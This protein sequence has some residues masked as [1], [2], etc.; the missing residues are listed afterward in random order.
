M[1]VDTPAG[2]RTCSVRVVRTRPSPE[3]SP[4]GRGM[5]V[6]YPRQVGQ[7]WAVRMSPRKLRWIW[8]TSPAP[9][10]VVQVTGSEPGSPP[11]PLHLGHTTAVSTLSGFVTPKTASCSWSET[12]T[13]ASWPWRTRD[14]GPRPPAAPNIASTRLEKSNPPAN[15]PPKPEKPAPWLIGSPPRSNTARLL[16][17]LRTS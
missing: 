13:S 14:R 12:L 7:A 9:S 4:H 2:I 11:A 15:P 1:P 10:H 16:G 6:P 3:H 5:T 8:L 17:S